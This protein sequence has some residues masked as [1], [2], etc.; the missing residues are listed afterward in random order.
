[1]ARPPKGK[2]PVTSALAR[3]DTTSAKDKYIEIASAFERADRL[4]DL[5]SMLGSDE[6]VRRF[7]SVALH[8]I[9]TDNKLLRNATPFSIIQAVRDSATLGLEPTGLTGEAWI[10][11][12]GDQAK[13]MPGWRGYL[14]RIRNSR[15]VQD[16]DVQLVYVNDQFDYGWRQNG[17][18]FEHHPAKPV[19]MA[20]GGFED[21]RGDFWGAYAYA[22]M[23][24][25]F[26]ELEVM[27]EADI[28]FI[29]DTYSKA[30]DED[31]PWRKSWG[32]M[33]RKTVVRRLA[34]RL[35]QEAVDQLLRLDAEADAARETVTV[36]KSRFSP[37]AARQAALRAVGIEADEQPALPAGKA[38]EASE[39]GTDKGPQTAPV[40]TPAV[41]DEVH[42][43]DLSD[44]PPSWQPE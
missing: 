30:K 21:P 7:L 32:E 9:S 13:L 23:P 16:V 15:Q 40:E 29:R 27:T 11:V 4:A 3:A 35:P 28:N 24:S 41:K 34:K 8:S 38:P 22:V 20:D 12:Y 10:V 36:E 18:W 37:T 2:P 6:G 5:R 25:G 17:G 39:D 42:E 26:V 31:S 1:M 33:A 14:N 43:S 19:K 44:L